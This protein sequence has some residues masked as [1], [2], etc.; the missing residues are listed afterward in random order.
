M[1]ATHTNKPKSVV[2]S[3]PVSRTADYA[4]QGFLYQFNKTILAILESSGTA[5]IVVEG[6][7]EDIDIHD[8]TC[9]QAIQCKYH[10]T[11]TSFTLSAI[12]EPLLQMMLHFYKNPQQHISYRLFAHFP[13]KSELDT[14]AIGKTDIATI[15]ESQNKD[16]LAYISELKHN[17]D[18]DAFLAKFVFEFGQPLGE[19]IES[20]ITTFVSCGFERSDITDVIYPNALHIIGSTSV[21]HNHLE[22]RITKADFVKS[23]YEIKKT[24]ISRWTLSLFGVKKVLDARRKQLKQA[25]SRNVRRRY[26]LIS[27]EIKDFKEEIVILISEFVK[28]YHFKAAHTETPL[29]C[30]DCDSAT[31]EDIRQRI[32]SKGISFNDGYIGSRFDRSHFC[33]NPIVIASK[34]HPKREF[35]IRLARFETDPEVINTPK[36]EDIFVIGS[37]NYLQLNLVDVNDERLAAETLQQVK[38]ILGVSDAYD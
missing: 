31:F 22:R 18:V 16:L 33:R 6:V 9:I 14:V 37:G 34:D 5:E 13:G 30:L 26:F 19:L 21:K 2:A 35:L 4:I 1:S 10:E 8:A 7:I 25:L 27:E 17:V 38:Y 24:I 29:F 36:C 20:V 23:L 11:K 15:M 32:H 3:A 12:Y 28:K